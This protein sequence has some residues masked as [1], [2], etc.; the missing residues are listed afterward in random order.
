MK[1][2]WLLIH[3]LIVWFI[4]KDLLR[5]YLKDDDYYYFYTTIK[6]Y[7]SKNMHITFRYLP[8]SLCQLYNASKIA[9]AIIIERVETTINYC[10]N[11]FDSFMN[12]KMIT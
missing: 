11:K 1:N 7:E 10:I 12:K 4:K 2:N 3:C 6:L 5:I 8:D 9:M